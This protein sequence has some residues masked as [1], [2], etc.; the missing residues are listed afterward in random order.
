MIELTAL[1]RLDIIE[2]QSIYAWGIDMKEGSKFALA[3]A[4]D[5]ETDY[6][7]LGRMKGLDFFTRWMDTFHAPFDATQHLIS[8]HWLTVEG[9]EVVYRSY[10]IA[11]MV[12]KGAPGGDHMGGGG[13]YQDRV[14]RTDAGWRIRSR[15]VKN[16]WR[17]GNVGILEIGKQ[18]V[19]SL[20]A[21]LSVSSS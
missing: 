9:D 19:A 3:F 7:H 4:E 10:V 8:N 18:A 17:T 13:W 20:Y 12:C 6:G 2:L 14:V 5:I 15:D 1:D 11:N 16:I 21:E